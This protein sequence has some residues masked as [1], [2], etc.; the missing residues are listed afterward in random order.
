MANSDGYPWDSAD[1]KLAYERVFIPSPAQQAQMSLALALP[2]LP[3]Q[4]IREVMM[5]PPPMPPRF[6]LAGNGTDILTCWEDIQPVPAHS[7]MDYSNDE[8]ALQSTTRPS[9]GQ[10]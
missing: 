2:A 10:W 3:A 7:I 8:A 9:L 5:T 1:D 4:R 6:G